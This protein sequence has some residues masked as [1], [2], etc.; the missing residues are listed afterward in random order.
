MIPS[1]DD[2]KFS[3]KRKGLKKRPSQVLKIMV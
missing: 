1:L 2:V 3:R